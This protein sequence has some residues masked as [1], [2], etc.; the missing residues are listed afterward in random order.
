MNKILGIFGKNFE[1]FKENFALII[2]NYLIQFQDNLLKCW[3]NFQENFIKIRK[4]TNWKKVE[5]IFRKFWVSFTAS[6][7]K[8]LTIYLWNLVA[9]FEKNRTF[10]NMRW[11]EEPRRKL[12]RKFR[13]NWEK[14]KLLFLKNSTNVNFKMLY[15]GDVWVFLNVF[16]LGAIEKHVKYRK[17]CG[18]VLILSNWYRYFCHH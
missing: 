7:T 11:C 10:V 8:F 12:G 4:D 17:Y 9:N 16:F 3:V 6:L 18:E 14:Q 5:K 1:N 15:R 2:I 13:E